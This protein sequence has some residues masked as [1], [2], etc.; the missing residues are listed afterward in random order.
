MCYGIPMEGRV[1]MVNEISQ[2]RRAP[3]TSTTT[4]TYDFPTVNGLWGRLNRVVTRHCNA[5]V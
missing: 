2:V 3:L 1:I 5:L 4:T